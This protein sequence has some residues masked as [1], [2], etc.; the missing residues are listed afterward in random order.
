M[1]WYKWIDPRDPDYDPD[2]PSMDEQENRR[3]DNLDDEMK[4]QRILEAEERE[5]NRI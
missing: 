1:P 2:Q 5:E 4:E 3:F